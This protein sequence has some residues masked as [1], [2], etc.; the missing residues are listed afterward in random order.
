MDEAEGSSSSVSGLSVCGEVLVIG[1]CLD[2]E[3]AEAVCPTC[4]G[5]A[6]TPRYGIATQ[7]MSAW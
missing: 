2:K 6:Q 5:A 1:L 3:R 7:L 4:P